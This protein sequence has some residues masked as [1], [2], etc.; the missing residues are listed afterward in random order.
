MN[1]ISRAKWDR[2]LNGMRY[3]VFNV[4]W[5]SPGIKEMWVRYSGDR[6]H[7][8]IHAPEMLSED[9]RDHVRRNVEVMIEAGKELD[10]AVFRGGYEIRYGRRRV[11]RG[12]GYRTLMSDRLFRE[13]ARKHAPWRLESGT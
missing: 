5:P 13:I 10:R 1:K 3:G 8:F 9:D 12:M 11:A 4:M 7:F 6:A 2:M